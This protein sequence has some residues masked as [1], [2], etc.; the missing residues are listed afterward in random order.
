MAFFSRRRN[1]NKITVYYFDNVE[2]R[3]KQ[4]PRRLTR[5]LDDMADAD[6]T[7]WVEKWEAA[8]GVVIDRT[9]RTL[10]KKS[11]ELTTLWA[12]FQA[13][14]KALRDISATTARSQDNLF[15]RHILEYFLVAHQEKNPRRWHTL[16]PGLVVHLRGRERLSLDQVKRI[17]WLMRRFG[18]YLQQYGILNHPWVI[19]IP[20]KRGRRPTPLKVALEP[21]TVMS[22]ARLLHEAGHNH[23][24][25][26]L[27]LGYFCSLSPSETYVLHRE[28]FLTGN[29]A[30]KRTRTVAGLTKYGLGS[31]LSVIINKALISSG[32][33]VLPKND[34]RFGTVNVWRKDA[35]LLIGAIL[36]VCLP[37]KLL[38]MTR[39]QLYGIHRKY[40]QKP[41]N[42]T[43]HDLRRA[44]CLY[45]G[46]VIALDPLLL[47]SHMR[48]AELST[49]MLYTRQPDQIDKIVAEADFDDVG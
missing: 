47:Q 1:S 29:V 9:Q 18:E 48:H 40:I 17:C 34:Y 2:G 46:R 43:A 13:D 11:D 14:H 15:R 49:T 7:A 21:D 3:Q 12:A 10:L 27:L 25:L 24:A 42:V 4:V 32:E 45:L 38:R 31:R 5:I 6:I 41:L 19:R 44:S 39:D 16:M 36:K 26:M 23:A 37:G 8:N 22:H 20:A 35:A 28:D 33:E 30:I